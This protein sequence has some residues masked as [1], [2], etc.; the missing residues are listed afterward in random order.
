MIPYGI[1]DGIPGCI[2]DLIKIVLVK[3]EFHSIHNLYLSA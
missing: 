3:I 1:I 2:P